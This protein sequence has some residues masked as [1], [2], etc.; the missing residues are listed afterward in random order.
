MPQLPLFQCPNLYLDF[1]YFLL[2][3]VILCLVS[4][5]VGI[6][7]CQGSGEYWLQ[8]FDTYGATYGLLTIAFFEIVVV[9]YIYGIKKYVRYYIIR[10]FLDL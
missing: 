1:P 10:Y 9:V 4:F 2:A 7:F 6:I 8:I 3:L 5:T